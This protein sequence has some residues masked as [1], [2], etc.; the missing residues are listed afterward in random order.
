MSHNEVKN[1]FARFLFQQAIDQIA[2]NA[3]KSG[4]SMGFTFAAFAY[5][6]ALMLTA[7]LI[8][9]AIYVVCCAKLYICKFSFFASC[10]HVSVLNYLP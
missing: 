10:T 5:I 1:G 6:V 4:G 9:F 7:F 3:A 8:F 2:K